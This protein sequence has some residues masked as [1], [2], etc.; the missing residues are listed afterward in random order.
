MAESEGRRKYRE[1]RPG[2][3]EA[4]TVAMFRERGI[5]CNVLDVGENTHIVT[6]FGALPEED[7]GETDN[8]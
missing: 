7:D 6:F 5:E 3:K 8:A 2:T 4:E 1:P